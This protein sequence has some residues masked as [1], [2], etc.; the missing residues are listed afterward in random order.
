MVKPYKC[1]EVKF[2]SDYILNPYR[3]LGKK[4]G[5]TIKIEPIP[6]ARVDF[7]GL[8]DSDCLA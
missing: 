1:G 8:M 7:S 5:A 3:M 2:I 6:T 4:I